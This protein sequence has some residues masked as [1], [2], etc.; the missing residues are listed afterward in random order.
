MKN[1]FKTE[2]NDLVSAVQ[3]NPAS[4]SFEMQELINR[5]S[6]IYIDIVNNYIPSDC[7]FLSKIDILEEKNYRIYLAALKFDEDKGAKFST[8]LGNETKW[9]C[10]NMFNK[11][12]KCQ[13]FT[14]E[15]DYQAEEHDSTHNIIN[16]E[17][18]EQILSLAKKHPD[19]RVY[20]IFKYR[21][22]DG[23]LNKLMTWQK[24]AKK[25]K[26][27]IQGC[28]NIHNSAID[29]FKNKLNKEINNV[30]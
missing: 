3:A 5:H 27:S 25:L 12:K 21:Y 28:I 17:S 13:K 30:K 7:N 19:K 14:I 1:T 9:M 11:N 22:I 29:Y 10:L 2:D 24:I 16:S 20:K 8:Y 18:L 6:G 4:S 26:M 15:D 23:N